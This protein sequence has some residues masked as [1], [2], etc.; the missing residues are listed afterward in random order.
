MPRTRALPPSFSQ[1]TL[2]RHLL[3]AWFCAGTWV[4][5]SQGTAMPH[6]L[7]EADGHTDDEDGGD[8]SDHGHDQGNLLRAHSA[9]STVLST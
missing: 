2:T 6:S 3:C 9:P 8:D 4:Q 5:D 1:E 7:G